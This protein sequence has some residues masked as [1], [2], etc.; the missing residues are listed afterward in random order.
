[1]K[2][3]AFFRSKSGRRD[4]NHAA[5]VAGL[6]ALGHFVVD[7]AGVGDGVPDLLVWPY[8]PGALEAAPRFIELKVGKGK[9]RASQRYWRM[10]AEL[11]GI[12]VATARSLDEALEVLRG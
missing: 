2:G 12:R 11:R 6:R 10:G 9:L 7:L 8:R 4:A 3:P 1:M 5:I